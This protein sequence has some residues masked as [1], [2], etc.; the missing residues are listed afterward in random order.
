MSDRGCVTD[1]GSSSDDTA[2]ST[3]RL[4]PSATAVARR[5]ARGCGAAGLSVVAVL[6]WKKKR[7][8]LWV[9]TQIDNGQSSEA[10]R[11]QA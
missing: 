1:G 10:Q 3:P 9:R 2:A 4:I 11:S 7:R 5:A 8:R 6:S